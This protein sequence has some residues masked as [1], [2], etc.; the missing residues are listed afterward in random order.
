MEESQLMEA[1][2]IEWD[3]GMDS[4]ESMD[5][6]DDEDDHCNNE[7]DGFSASRSN[8]LQAFLHCFPITIF[9]LILCLAVSSNAGEEDD[10]AEDDEEDG[11]VMRIRPTRKDEKELKRTLV[12]GRR[13]QPSLSHLRRSGRTSGKDESR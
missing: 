4:E 13:K 8:R 6:D 7:S 12:D 2:T 5:D 9:I 1:S 10:E 11:I 3:A